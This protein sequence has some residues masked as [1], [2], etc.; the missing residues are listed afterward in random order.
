[1]ANVITSAIINPPPPKG[2]IRAMHI[3]DKAK[4]RINKMTREKM[5]RVFKENFPSSEKCLDR[6][7][8][9]TVNDAG[10]RTGAICYKLWIENEEEKL[11]EP[12]QYKMFV[13]ILKAPPQARLV[14]I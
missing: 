11:K 2:A 14:L 3:S 10:D 7:N 12:E 1:M 6:R 5:V 4:N 13:P 8:F 9:L